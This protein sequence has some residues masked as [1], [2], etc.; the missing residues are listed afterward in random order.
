MKV[1]RLDKEMVGDDKVTNFYL[2]IPL[3]REFNIS[4]WDA[5]LKK[6]RRAGFWITWLIV[7]IIGRM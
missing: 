1:R 5:Y 4:W 7:Q 6:T 2:F 3:N